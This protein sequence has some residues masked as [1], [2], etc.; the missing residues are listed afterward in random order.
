[1]RSLTA[2]TMIFAFA[3]GAFAAPAHEISSV[4]E[5]RS[6][7]DDP[8]LPE[9]PNEDVD[10]PPNGG[11]AVDEDKPPLPVDEDKKS[12]DA[13]D[14]PPDPGD[15]PAVG[16]A[17]SHADAPNRPS[18]KT[19][20]GP[21]DCLNT[22]GAP[23]RAKKGVAGFASP[24]ARIQSG[25]LPAA[26]P[27]IDD[28]PSRARGA[29]AD[30]PSWYDP[31]LLVLPRLGFLLR[32]NSGFDEVCSASGGLRCE[33]EAGLD[34]DDESA[35]ALQLDILARLSRGVRVGAGLAWIPAVAFDAV[36][37]RRRLGTELDGLVILEG[38][39][40][41]SNQTA[42]VG[43]AHGGP[44]LLISGT[45]LDAEVEEARRDC[46]AIVSSEIQCKVND[47]PY[48]G[49]TYG[50]GVGPM[51]RFGQEP[52]VNV[53]TELVFQRYQVD[54]VGQKARGDV[55]KVNAATELVGNRFWLALAVEL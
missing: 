27:T 50:A 21:P 52:G 40:P 20:S 39:V 49:F 22:S 42:L 7:T 23:S 13:S 12:D 1:M 28:H 8:A 6:L 31:A 41:L 34:Q 55:G 17:D 9:V 2:A 25:S 46:D 24:K 51:F 19:T 4:D 35:V 29:R 45:S 48:V 16:S 36:G 47:G 38:A 26:R 44:L 18:T 10:A 11:G 15:A 43:R 5:P 14:K 37:T 53:R 32:G 3:N 30:D 54:T 33:P